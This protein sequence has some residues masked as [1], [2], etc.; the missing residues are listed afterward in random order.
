METFRLHLKSFHVQPKS[1]PL[2]KSPAFLF[3]EEEEGNKDDDDDDSD[4]EDDDYD[5]ND[6]GRGHELREGSG[7]LVVAAERTGHL[8][9][10]GNC[11]KFCFLLW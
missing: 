1:V 9:D 6:V 8:Y 3:E 4:D 7:G 2:I 11:L 10:V 5:D